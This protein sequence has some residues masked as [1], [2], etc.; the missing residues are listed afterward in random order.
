[1]GAKEKNMFLFSELKFT[2]AAEQEQLRA[3]NRLLSAEVE[4]LERER[5]EMKKVFR[6]QAMHRGVR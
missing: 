3:I 4:R 6:K 2:K 1:M 5:I